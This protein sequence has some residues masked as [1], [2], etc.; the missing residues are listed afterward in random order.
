MPNQTLVKMMF[1]SHVY[2]TNLPTSDRDYKGVFIPDAQ[3]LVMQRAAKHIRN[4]TKKDDSKRNTAED[5]DD[6]LFSFQTYMELIR[7][8]QTVA[9]DMLFTPERFYCSDV[10]VH[11]R[12][13]EI[14]ANR[15]HLIHKGTNAFVGYT[16]AQAAKYGHKG[17][18]LAALNLFMNAM[19]DWDGHRELGEYTAELGKLVVEANS[20]EAEI[21]RIPTPN[22]SS[23]EMREMSHLS[24]ANKKV[25]YT[26]TVDYARQVYKLALDKYGHRARLA[27]TNDGIDWKATMHAVRI[28][29]EAKELLLTGF[30]TFP[31]PEAELLVKIRT[32]QIPYKEVEALVEKGLSDIEDAEKK[33]VLADKPNYKLMDELVSNA[34]WS[35]IRRA[36]ADSA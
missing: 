27:E 14:V 6:E 28:A 35:A 13:L 1:G 17:D 20:K 22:G 31:R 18:R 23:G 3:E 32:G 7:Q 15:D 2:G 12:W 29:A 4:S 5:V 30:I 8:G 11:S 24:L 21:V 25:G 19:K 9:L 34:H 10:P 36:V 16:K 33:S 26:C